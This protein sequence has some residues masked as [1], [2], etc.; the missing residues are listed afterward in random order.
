MD[1]EMQN[2][3]PIESNSTENTEP[4]SNPTPNTTNTT[5][6][7]KKGFSIASMI[8]GIVAVV[9]CCLW[10]ITIPCGILAIVFSIVGK[11]KGGKGMATA[12]LV[13]GIIAIALYVL[14]IIC[15]VGALMGL[16]SISNLE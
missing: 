14:L 13:L 6:P 11:K 5:A 7:E 16:A 15:G 4:I 12:G 10:Y 3:N 8:L 2:N 9:F 1:N